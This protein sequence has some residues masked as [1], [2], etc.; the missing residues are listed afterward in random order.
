MNNIYLRLPVLLPVIFITIFFLMSGKVDCQTNTHRGYEH[1]YLGLNLGSSSFYGDISERKRGL[2][3]SIPLT[4]NFYSNRNFMY[5]LTLSKHISPT[6]W[7][8]MNVLAGN[9]SSERI[10]KGLY[11]KSNVVELSSI[12]MLNLSE[13]IWGRDRE[14]IFK[15]YIFAGAG[16]TL[17]SSWKRDILTDTLVD[18]E[19]IGKNNASSLV[20]PAGMGLEYVVTD[21]FTIQGEFSLRNLG[22]DR[23]DAH[24]NETR[25]PEGYGFI[26][27]GLNYRIEMPESLWPRRNPYTG[28]SNDPA[29]RAYNRRKAV[30][31]KTDGYKRGI[32][33]RRKFERQHREWF[34]FELFRKTTLDMA[35]E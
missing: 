34:I 16:V 32:R 21:R 22:S 28:K 20:I 19:G 17:H 8:R 18:S 10:D 13:M 3:H 7:A 29:L 11:F 9:I 23:L 24:T 14:R 33:D 1:W 31:M 26:T 4:G 15:L 25:S 6:F 30:V 2:S 27:I 12:I 35:K 5:G